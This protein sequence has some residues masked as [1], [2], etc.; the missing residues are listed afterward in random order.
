MNGCSAKSSPENEACKSW[1]AG[2][3]YKGA[4]IAIPEIAD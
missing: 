3:A 4:E 1:L 2:I